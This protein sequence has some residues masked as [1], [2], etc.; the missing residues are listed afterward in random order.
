MYG[1]WECSLSEPVEELRTMSRDIIVGVDFHATREN[2]LFESFF[3][4]RFR[5]L[6]AA[7]KS[8]YRALMLQ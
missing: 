2:I 3:R 8:D 4:H 6:F 7:D 1:L 5:Q